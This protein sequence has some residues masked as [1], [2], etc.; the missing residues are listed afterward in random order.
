MKV[1]KIIKDLSIEAYHYEEPYMS[2]ISASGLKQAKNSLK[3][4]KHYQDSKATRERKIHFDF[5]NAF[6][7][8]LLDTREFMSKVAVFDDRVLCRAILEERPELKSV[9]SSKEYKA[10]KADFEKEASVKKQYIINDFDDHSIETIQQML[11]SCNSEPTIK[12]LLSKVEYQDSFFWE[13]PETG[14]KLKTRPDVSIVN[15][16]N[17]ID[18]KTV[19]NGD[20]SP[21]NVANTISKLN[22]TTQACMQID[23]VQQAG[24]I[25]EVDNYFW[26]FVEKSA[27]FDAVLYEFSKEDREV[28]MAE[29]RRTLKRVASAVAS[30]D[31]PGY[32][33]EANNEFGILTAKIW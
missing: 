31:Y 29:Y 13:C 10:I 1:E 32:K 25:D 15:K 21:R 24:Y 4:F 11:I 5:G 18:I 22:Y 8:A 16:K 17:I 27:P 19:G 3:A 23:G 7:L 28:K 30:G 33:E 26:L 9:R 2:Y 14:L 12:A 6:E 20:A